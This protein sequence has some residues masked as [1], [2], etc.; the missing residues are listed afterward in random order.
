MQKPLED[1]SRFADA[2]DQIVVENLAQ[3]RET[4][5]RRDRMGQVG[6]AVLEEARAVGDGVVDGSGAQHGADW[7]VA[8]AESLGDADDVRRDAFGLAGEQASGAAHAAHHLVENEKHAVP[9]A[10]LPDAGE[11]SLDRRDGAEGR[12]RDGL[13][14]KR[15]HAVAAEPEDLVLQLP[16]QALAVFG[17]GLA[18]GSLG[19]FV[20]GGHVA[21]RGEKRGVLLAPPE[22]PARGQRAQRAAV[23]ALAAGDDMAALRLA[24]LEMALARQLDGGLDRLGAAGDEIGPIESAWGVRD[25]QRGEILGRAR[26]EESGVGERQGLRLLDDRPL[27][28]FVGVA[29]AGHGGAA[30][31]V[32]VALAGLV[33]QEASV[34][35]DRNGDLGVAVSWKDVAHETG[36][37]R[38]IPPIP[39]RTAR[40]W[41]LASGSARRRKRPAPGAESAALGSGDETEGVTAAKMSHFLPGMHG[42]DSLRRPGCSPGPSEPRL[43]LPRRENPPLSQGGNSRRR[44]CM[45]GR[46]APCR[47]KRPVRSH[48]RGCGAGISC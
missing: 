40:T 48:P 43:A 24:A 31:S 39:G 34:A 36:L 13:G 5:R 30:R 37:H 32:E 2:G 35:A 38:R 29:E 11:V 20:A 10:D 3:D 44:A 42:A 45:P 28:A 6:V 15:D 17:R 7:L 33:D 22:I 16:R 41:G 26:G 18:L 1:R 12:S 14:Q 21:R 4:R 46:G 23:V 8:R 9:V 25:Q 19:V 27:D 47:G